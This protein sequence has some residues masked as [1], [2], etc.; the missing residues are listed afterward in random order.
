M[1][2]A[3]DGAVS[4][5]ATAAAASA[6][7]PTWDAGA[8]RPVG[9]LLVCWAAGTTTGVATVPGTP[10]GWS[11]ATPSVIESGTSGQAVSIIFYKIATGGDTAPTIAGAAGMTWFVQIGSWTGN[12]TSSPI[13]KTGSVNA[14][15]S[16]GVPTNS[17]VDAAIGELFCY[18]G[19]EFITTAATS[20]AFVSTPTNFTANDTTNK[21]TISASHYLFGWGITTANAVAD[22]DSITFDS[23]TS[24]LACVCGSFKLPPPANTP[25]FQPIPF[26]GGH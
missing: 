13:D 16:P 2:Y 1:A 21:A 26:M 12:D 9:A 23:A 14:A 10:S 18:M 6:V 5:V 11:T 8:T 25:A 4:A 19:T 17:G 24:N 3:Q 15:A 7:T 22:K 20:A